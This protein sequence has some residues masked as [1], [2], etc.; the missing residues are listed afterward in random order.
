V[1]SRPVGEKTQEIGG[2]RVTLAA[3]C[4]AHGIDGDVAARTELDRVWT[5]VDKIRAKQATKPNASP[6]PGACI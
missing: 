6:L 1:F 2:V 5:V 3:L 4:N